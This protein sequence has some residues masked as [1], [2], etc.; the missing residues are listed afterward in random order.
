VTPPIVLVDTSVLCHLLSVP[1]MDARHDE[2]EH[3]F[4]QRISDGQKLI[5]PFACILELGN[6]IAQCGDGDQR[7]K[8]ADRLVRFVTLALSDSQPYSSTGP[9][10]VEELRWAL[11][12]FPE[13]AVQKV[14]LADRLI[15][16]EQQRLQRQAA[17]RKVE[18]WTF[19]QTLAAHG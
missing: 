14:G 16:E 9:I 18:I 10:S 3:E 8:T 15:L 6:H 2:V 7:R 11:D 13:F 5:V 12:G 17:G 1:L 19:D 4:R